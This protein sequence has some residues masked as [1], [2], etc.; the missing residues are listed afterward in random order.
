MRDGFAHLDKVVAITLTQKTGSSQD[1]VDNFYVFR[2]ILR[3]RYGVKMRYFWVKEFTPEPHDYVDRHG[4]LR[5]SQGGE[6]HLH[7]LTDTRIGQKCL[8]RL[9]REVTDG[10]SYIVWINQTE[11]QNAAGYAMKYLTKGFETAPYDE[12][13]RRY[14]FSRHPEFKV[15]FQRNRE[16]LPILGD[17]WAIICYARDKC[18][19]GTFSLE[20][21]AGDYESFTEEEL[22]SII[23]KRA[24]QEAGCAE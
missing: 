10:E 14:G 1:I 21:H 2:N 13:E 23:Q 7:I 4:V 20:Y 9:W 19:D 12:N 15:S 16:A 6:R 24:S 22:C 8:S 11:I 18:R 3:R 5:R 17:F